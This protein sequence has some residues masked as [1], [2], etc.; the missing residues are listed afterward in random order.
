MLYGNFWYS[1]WNGLAIYL[2]KHCSDDNKFNQTNVTPVM[3]RMGGFSIYR[4]LQPE[5]LFI[6]KI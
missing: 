5:E 3:M 2:I 6:R 4:K 1:E